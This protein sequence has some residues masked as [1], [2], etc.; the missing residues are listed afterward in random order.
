MARPIIAAVNVNA[1]T[2]ETFVVLDQRM[3]VVEEQTNALL[4]DLQTLGVNSHRYS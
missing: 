1:T 2:P 4:K 3:R